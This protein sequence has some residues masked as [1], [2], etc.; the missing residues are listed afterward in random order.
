MT[1]RISPF[2]HFVEK[3][4]I[5]IFDCDGVILDS[6]QI[7][8]EA[9]YEICLP[10]GKEK[11]ELMVSYHKEH[12]GISRFEKF[13]WFLR[14]ILQKDIDPIEHKRMCEN[15][16]LL[17]KNKLL[18]C[19]YTDGFIEF[20]GRLNAL[21]I[22]PY[23][24]SGGLESELKEIFTNRRLVNY[25]S[26]VFGSP[27]NKIEILS[28][29]SSAGIGLSSGIFIGDSKADYD[30]SKA[31]GMEF[32][33]LRKYSESMHWFKSIDSTSINSFESF[34]EML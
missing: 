27:R 20:L 13:N 4:K 10:Y 30:A 3:H 7:K 26:D 32:V 5:W 22:K 9:F 28:S 2:S 31:F 15:F 19:N 23:V 1:S 6:N 25:F 14:T 34:S 18:K 11:A 12:G 8:T 21:Q 24:V 17:V 16:G 29:I 33:F